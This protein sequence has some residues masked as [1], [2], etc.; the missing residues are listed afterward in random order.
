MIDICGPCNAKMGTTSEVPAKPIV[1]ALALNGWRARYRREEWRAVGLWWSKVL[2]LV[3]HDEAQLE[4]PR[5]QT[6]VG[7][8]FEPPMPDLRWLTDGTGVPDH[9]SVFVHNANMNVEDTESA[10]SIPIQVNFNDGRTAHCHLLS[11]ATPGLCV[12]VVSHPGIE[13]THPMVK[14]RRAWELLHSPPG[15]TT[16]A[17]CNRSGRSTSGT[18]GAEECLRGTWQTTVGSSSW[19][20]RSGMRLTRSRLRACGRA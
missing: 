13:I 10:L 16:S 2:L 7:Y 20:R 5:L 12:T 14:K 6:A 11:M 4:N 9:V 15:A 17:G 19:S 1:T 18:S 3:G 8:T